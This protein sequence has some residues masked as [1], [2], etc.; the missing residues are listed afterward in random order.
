[1]NKDLNPLDLIGKYNSIIFGTIL[2]L[3]VLFMGVGILQIVNTQK[4]DAYY[5]QSKKDIDTKFDTAT[6]QRIGE[7]QN[8][9]SSQ[10]VDLLPSRNP[11]KN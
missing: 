9:E 5:A 6:L 10:D 2:L 8:S 3:V 7:L 4:D 11:F 1:M